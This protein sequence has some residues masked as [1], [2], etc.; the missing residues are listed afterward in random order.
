MAFAITDGLLSSQIGTGADIFS[1]LYEKLANEMLPSDNGKLGENSPTA[2]SVIIMATTSV[3]GS[4]LRLS[5]QQDSENVVSKEVLSMLFACSPVV[6]LGAPV[7][8]LFLVKRNKKRLRYDVKDW[9][10]IVAVMF[11]VLCCLVLH[12]RF[13]R[14]GRSEARNDTL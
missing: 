10:A 8:S 12:F 1:Y 6:V 7:G 11:S 2:M 14:S 9:S 13:S 5:A 4:V 3:C